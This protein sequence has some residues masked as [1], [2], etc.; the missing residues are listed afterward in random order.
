[1]RLTES[2]GTIRPRPLQKGDTIGITAPSS[3]LSIKHVGNFAKAIEKRGFKVLLGETVTYML[4]KDYN[5]GSPKERARDFNRM[6]EDPSVKAIWAGAGGFGAQTLA[7]HLDFAAIE[8]NPKIIIGFSDTTFLLNAINH[9]TGLTTFL[10]PT[11]EVDAEADLKSLDNALAIL[12]G[13]IEYPNLITNFDEALIRRVSS[14]DKQGVGKI[15]GGNITMIQTTLGTEWQ[16][17]TTGKIICLEEVG[18]SSYSVER[19]LEHMRAGGMFDAPAA[20]VL[21]TK[22]L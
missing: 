11:G 16:H 3:Q 15:I 1:M 5:A 22:S 9:K 10:G 7:P 13:E 2:I 8:R 4:D 19:S 18:E 20:V 6:V 17:D 21:S 12:T 14:S